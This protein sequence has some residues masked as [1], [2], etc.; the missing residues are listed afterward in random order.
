[1]K[2][3]SPGILNTSR[4]P[5]TITT[6][7][8][9]SREGEALYVIYITAQNSILIFKGYTGNINVISYHTFLFL[10]IRTSLFLL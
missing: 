4:K 7:R 5:T 2:G 1:M 3:D 9:K 10:G 8:R 6:A